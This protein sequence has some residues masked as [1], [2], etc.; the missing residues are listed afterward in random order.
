MLGACQGITNNQP[1]AAG[2]AASPNGF[3][4]NWDYYNGRA[5]SLALISNGGVVSAG[6][7]LKPGLTD[8]SHAGRGAWTGSGFAFVWTAVDAVTTYGPGAPVVKLNALVS[9][10]TPGAT[11]AIQDMQ[12][13]GGRLSGY[14]YVVEGFTGKVIVRRFEDL[15]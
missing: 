6:P 5:N 10:F 12:A 3:L 8:Y 9:P 14:L 1:R 13:P 11:G 2:V 4:V 7:L 15:R